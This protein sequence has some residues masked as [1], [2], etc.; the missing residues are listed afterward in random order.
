MGE[1]EG[2]EDEEQATVGVQRLC[3]LLTA[4]FGCEQK[5]NQFGRNQ[6]RLPPP[7]VPCHQ[8]AYLFDLVLEPQHHNNNKS[9]YPTCPS[10]PPTHSQ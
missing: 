6:F 7:S 5:R 1:W 4:D 3:T 2:Y 8:L 10:P 9:T